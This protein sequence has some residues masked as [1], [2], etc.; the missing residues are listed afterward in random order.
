MTDFSITDFEPSEL[1]VKKNTEF[2][3]GYSFA[4]QARTTE[5]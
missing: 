1:H 5:K 2:Q 3:F 4:A